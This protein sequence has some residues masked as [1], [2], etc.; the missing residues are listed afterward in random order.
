MANTEMIID[1]QEEENVSDF[2]KFCNYT[3]KRKI[4]DVS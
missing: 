1:T 3:K 2:D 4:Y